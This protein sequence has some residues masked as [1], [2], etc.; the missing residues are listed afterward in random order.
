MLAV[1]AVLALGGAIGQTLSARSA[2]RASITFGFTTRFS[3]PELLPY[4]RKT[5][6][7][8]K[9]EGSPEAM[10]AAYGEMDYAEQLATMVVP[11][12]MEELAGLYNRGLLDK[13][14]TRDFFGDLARNLWVSGSWLFGPWREEDS[15]YFAQW[16]LM[17]KRMKLVD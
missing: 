1:A 3:N 14:I 7:V 10:F 15:A 13:K 5:I 6:E 2:T 12:L 11:N 4:I 9:S 17:L 16:L 8:F